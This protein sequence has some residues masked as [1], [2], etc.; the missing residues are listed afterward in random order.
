[1]NKQAP[2]NCGYKRR[3]FLARGLCLGS[4]AATLPLIASVPA[5]AD[6]ACVTP[7]SESLRMSMLY[8]DPASDPQESC[9]TCGYFTSHEEG[10]CG[11]CILMSGPVHRTAH[12]EGWDPKQDY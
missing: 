11:D 2:E 10:N 3:E 4:I 1:M 12:C 9:S 7:V 5:R 8:Q 6:S